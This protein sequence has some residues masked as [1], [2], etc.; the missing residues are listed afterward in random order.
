[1][2]CIEV[3]C[4]CFL[5]MIQEKKLLRLTFGRKAKV[6]KKRF[7]GGGRLIYRIT[8]PAMIKNTSRNMIIPQSQT[9][10]KLQYANEIT[11]EPTSSLSA[12]GSRNDPN[13]LA[14]DTQFRAIKPSN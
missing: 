13:L 6:Q 5:K 4:K 3:T 12:I 14:C 8:R 1:M 10:N 2:C 9:G 7:T 11:K